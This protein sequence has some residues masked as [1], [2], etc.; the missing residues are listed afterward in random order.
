[1]SADQTSVTVGK[2][3]I[4]VSRV[5]LGTA[6]LGSLYTS[7]PEAQGVATIQAAWEAGVRF[8][9]TAPYYGA[10]QAERYLGAALRGSHATM[11][12]SPPRLGASCSPT[13]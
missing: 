8:F 5:A 2:T 13:A 12:S 11:W 1:M 7:I 10:G 6:P 9:D 4:S 3:G